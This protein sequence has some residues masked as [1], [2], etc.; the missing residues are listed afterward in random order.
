[1][2]SE[3][4]VF[5][6]AARYH[7]PSSPGQHTVRVLVHDSGVLYISGH[8]IEVRCRL[9]D[10]TIS[11]PVLGDTLESLGL[12]GG[13]KCETRDAAAVRRLRQLVG[14]RTPFDWVP[15]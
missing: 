1:M 2:M 9:E 4:A 15:R 3:G 12:P 7:E 11:A 14:R 8:G 6:L 13:A 10:L 5:E